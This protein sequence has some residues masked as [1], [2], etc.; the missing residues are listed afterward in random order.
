MTAR[1]YAPDRARQLR[2]LL[3]VVVAMATFLTLV[4]AVLLLVGGVDVAQ[5][6]FVLVVPALVLLG[7]GSWSM[8]LL[9]DDRAGARAAIVGTAVVAILEGLLLSR[10]GPGLLVG[11]VGILLLLV[12]V[13]PGREVPT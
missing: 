12:A 3:W 4:A 1:T 9:A 11:V 13:L 5:V 8:S 7:L 2:L 10:V 6:L